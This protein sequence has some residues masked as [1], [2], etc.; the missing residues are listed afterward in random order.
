M[1]TCCRATSTTELFRNVARDEGFPP[2][3]AAGKS[4]MAQSTSCNMYNVALGD[5][6]AIASQL[7]AAF[8]TRHGA[9]Q[10][11]ARY[12]AMA[13]RQQPDPALA[14]SSAIISGCDFDNTIDG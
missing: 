10:S 13:I 3:S 6:K 7:I 9:V 2:E 1:M 8:R 4:N 12:V 5:F 14:Q 11:G